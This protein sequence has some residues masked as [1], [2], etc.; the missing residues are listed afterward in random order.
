MGSVHAEVT[1]KNLEDGMKARIGLIKEDEVR[2]ETVKA[3]VDTSSMSLVITEELSQKLGLR[4]VGNRKSRVANGH[5]E[6]CKITESIEVHWK[7]RWTTLH[8]LVLPGLRRPLLGVIPLEDMDL[9]VNPVTQELVGAH[10]DVQETMIMT[11]FEEG[12]IE[13]FSE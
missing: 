3:L 4:T 7:D 11:P 1:L 13:F 2:S 8:A 10:G 9:M 5:V 12:E 6:L